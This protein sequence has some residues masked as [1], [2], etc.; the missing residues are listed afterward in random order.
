MFSTDIAD[1]IESICETAKEF[2]RSDDKEI[3][4]KALALLERAL[5]MLE[6]EM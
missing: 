3:Q 5:T 4:E 1:A 6:D 2:A